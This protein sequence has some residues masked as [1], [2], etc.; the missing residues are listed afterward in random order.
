LSEKVYRETSGQP[1]EAVGFIRQRLEQLGPVMYNN[2]NFGSYLDFALP[3]RKTFIDGR[4]EL[5]GLD[6]LR[7]QLAIVNGAPEGARKLEEWGV[8]WAIFHSGSPLAQRL[9]AAGWTM[10]YADRVAIVY[11]KP[12]KPGGKPAR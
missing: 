11:V 4:D 8:D 5:F 2:H 12:P 6:F 7:E 1:V 9:E 10:F 3:E